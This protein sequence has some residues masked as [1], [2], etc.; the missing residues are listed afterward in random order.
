MMRILFTTVVLSALLFA[1]ISSPSFAHASNISQAI[2]SF[3]ETLYPKGSHYFWVINDSTTESQKEM[4]IDINAML[5]GEVDEAT[6]QQ[7]FL[8]LFINNELYAAQK[9][10]LGAKVD[11]KQEEEV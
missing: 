4:I 8:L 1:P 5:H 9:I 2:N 6:Q 7:R 3:V 11:C 10:S